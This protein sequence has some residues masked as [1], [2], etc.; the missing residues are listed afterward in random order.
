MFSDEAT[1]HTCGKESRHNIRIWGSEN[2]H[3][4]RKHVRDSK[5]VNV[6]C[7][8][9]KDRIIGPFFFIEPAVTGNIYLD[10]LEQFAVPQLLP[11]Q[12]N[13]I[14]QQQDGAPPHWSLDVRDFLDRTV[15]Q[16][17]IGRDGPTRWPPRSPD[18]TPLDFF[19]WGYVK[20]RVFCHPDTRCCWTPQKNYGCHPHPHIWYTEKHMGWNEYRLDIL[21]ATNGAHVE[22]YWVK[23]FE[24]LYRTPQTTR[25][26][27]SQ[28]PPKLIC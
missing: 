20:D 3:S 11:Q 13:V 15:P 12:P 19:L 28:L 8:M 17:W 22:V 24:L 2:L 23:P 1:F 18:I 14:S 25:L 21:R 26:H 27:Q 5:Q 7:G 4:A 6:W 16:R 9:M 10:T